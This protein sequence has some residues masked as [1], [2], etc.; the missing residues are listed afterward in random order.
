RRTRRVARAGP[1]GGRSDGDERALGKVLSKI[2]DGTRT[3]SVFYVVRKPL[4]FLAQYG[5]IKNRTI[6]I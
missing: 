2:K 4:A 5:I 1:S 3:R 6:I